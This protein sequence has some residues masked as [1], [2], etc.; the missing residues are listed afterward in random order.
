M[1]NDLIIDNEL[2]LMAI[3]CAFFYTS[4]MKFNSSVLS[5]AADE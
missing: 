5:M 2:I 4:L 1:K 3:H